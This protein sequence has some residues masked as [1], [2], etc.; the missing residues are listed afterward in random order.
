MIMKKL[1]LF[2]LP[3]VILIL[4]CCNNT[5]D[6]DDVNPKEGTAFSIM[7]DED[8]VIA[9][10]FC[11]ESGSGNFI[12]DPALAQDLIRHFDTVYRGAGTPQTQPD[13]R[14]NYWVD[15]CI[16]FALDTFFRDSARF[17]G[18]W[19]I[20]GADDESRQYKTNVFIVPTIYDA[21]TKRHINQW[22]VNIA[23]NNCV[24]TNY[25]SSML[26]AQP[27]IGEFRRHYRKDGTAS[28]KD[29][30]SKKV[31]INKCVFKSLAA[32]IKLHATSPDTLDHLDGI[33]IQSAAYRIKTP[34]LSSQVHPNQ[35]T[36]VIVTTRKGDGE[37]THDPAWDI[38][39][40]FYQFLVVKKRLVYNH[41][42][43]CP[44]SCGTNDL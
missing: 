28:E 39:N 23:G 7:S 41:G 27:K 8:F 40:K 6:K 34:A 37:G 33:S 38:T 31:W 15:S 14:P 22:D 11:E 29:S 21:P 35:S 12:I 32:I 25:F 26:N 36:I 19:I 1:F 16:V 44:N 42:E 17:D 10:D 43:L 4:V 30:L 9:K 24:Q 2:C 13:L 5:E 3:L 18:A 20:F